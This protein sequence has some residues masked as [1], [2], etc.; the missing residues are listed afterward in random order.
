MPSVRLLEPARAS[1]ATSIIGLAPAATPTDIFTMKGVAGKIIQLRRLVLSGLSTTAGQMVVSL[2]KRTVANTGGTA[3]APA[4][5]APSDAANDGASSVIM[6]Q[7]SVNPTALGAGVILRQRR[8][9]FQLAGGGT[10]DR[11]AWDFGDISRGTKS[12]RLN[13]ASEWFAINMNGGAVPAGG[14]I[15]IE[16]EWTEQ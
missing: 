11:I 15:D 13:G 6:A 16:V 12:L 5:P 1:F 7:Y 8:L 10:P 3:T 14:I 9:F 4:N 2:L